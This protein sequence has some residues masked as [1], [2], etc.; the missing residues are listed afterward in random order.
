MIVRFKSIRFRVF[1]VHERRRDVWTR[2][3]LWGHPKKSRGKIR[4]KTK[5]EGVEERF[6]EKEGQGWEID[7]DLRVVSESLESQNLKGKVFSVRIFST[8]KGI[9]RGH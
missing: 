5:E 3:E 9:I 8:R 4:A 6:R 2:G 7:T 1:T